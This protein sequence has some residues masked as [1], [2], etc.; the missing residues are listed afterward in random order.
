MNDF[1]FR[2]LYI[3]KQVGGRYYLIAG[4]TFFLFYVLWRTRI[5]HKKIQ[6]KF[7]AHRDYYRE[8]FFSSFTILLFAL[9]PT[10]IVFN[11]AVRPYTQLY[12]TIAERGWGYYF[13]LY[14]VLFFIHDTYFYWIHRFMHHPLL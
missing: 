1:F 14:P 12:S 9:I 5:Q 10:L 6:L 13:L 7:P 8:I 11:P 2:Y 3:V 4:I